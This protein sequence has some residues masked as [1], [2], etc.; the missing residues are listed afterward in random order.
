MGDC[1]EVELPPDVSSAEPGDVLE[2]KVELPPDVTDDENLAKCQV[3]SIRYLL[4]VLIFPVGVAWLGFCYLLSKLLPANHHWN[5][6]KAVSTCG[7]FLQIGFSTMSA[8]SL[9]PMMC[10]KHPNGLRSVLKYPN[11]ICGSDEHTAMLVIGWI[12]LV[13]FVLGFV[14]L[15]TFAV[16]QVPTWSANRR[17]HLVAAVRFLVFRFRLDSWWFG[18]PL[19][20]RGPLL[21]L[22][23][24]F[25]TDYP[26]IQVIAIA[27]I[28]SGLLV[29][30]MHFWPW[31][32]PVLNLT[33]CIVS[34]GI[35]LL[36]T[37]SSIHLKID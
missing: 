27:M 22:P 35:T 10:Y 4:S 5:W 7:A 6:S 28:M 23:V 19:L 15:C 36:V 25:A 17:D 12:L 31:K 30:Q 8:T 29:L 24:V 26:P 11:I 20:A 13:V 16:I 18:L 21:S 3:A 9:A 1:E 33:D 14:A 32:V 37:A 2:E 34:F